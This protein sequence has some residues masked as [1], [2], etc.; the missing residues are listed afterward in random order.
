MTKKP[1]IFRRIINRFGQKAALQMVFDRESGMTKSAIARKYHISPSYM[2]D[3]FMHLE[4]IT[5]FAIPPEFLLVDG[6]GED[7]LSTL[8]G[9]PERAAYLRSN[10]LFPVSPE[11]ASEFAAKLTADQHFSFV[12]NPSLRASVYWAHR[13]M[14]E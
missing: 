12:L 1:I 6:A 11:R 3:F 8:R 7:N 13:D 14:K 10:N 9:V 4:G 5:T 2:T